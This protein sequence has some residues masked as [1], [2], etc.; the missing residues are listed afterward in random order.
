MSIYT[1]QL[2]S[3]K[4]GLFD[5]HTLLATVSSNEICQAILSNIENNRRDVTFADPDRLYEAPVLRNPRRS[6]Q[7]PAQPLA[8]S[9]PSQLRP[10]P[11]VPLTPVDEPVPAMRA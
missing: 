2:P 1:E 7:R 8:Q 4:W 3:G 6:R 5:G 9:T 10:L 11:E